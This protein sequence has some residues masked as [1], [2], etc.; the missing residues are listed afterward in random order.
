MY[1]DRGRLYEGTV[2]LIDVRRARDRDRNDRAAGPLRDLQASFLEFVELGLVRVFVAGALREDKDRAALLY[3]FDRLHDDPK[4]LLY[5][6]A[7]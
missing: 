3:V 4:T 2:V 1:F 5:I 6:L 7:V